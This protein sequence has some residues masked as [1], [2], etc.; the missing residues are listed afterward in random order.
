[1]NAR[2]LRDLKSGQVYADGDYSWPGG[3][4]PSTKSIPV[5]TEQ[6]DGSRSVLFAGRLGSILVEQAFT[7][8]VN[9]PGVI[10]ERVTIRNATA[11]PVAAAEFKCG[12]AKRIREGPTW[13]EDAAGVRFYPV[14]YRRE[15]NGKMQEFPLREIAEHGMSYGGWA[16]PARQTPLWGAEGWVWGKGHSAFRLAKYNPAGMEW[17]LMESVKRG[18]ETV[19]RFGGAGQ[20]KHGHPEGSTRLDPGKSYSFGETRFQAVDGDWKQAYYI[21]AHKFPNVRPDRERKSET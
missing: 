20:W 17:S 21:T 7:A 10:L 11:S 15:T 18:T 6:K 16:E 8:P 2:S 9:E 19:V 3:A 14:P 5:I 1:M 12:F 13:S 4:F